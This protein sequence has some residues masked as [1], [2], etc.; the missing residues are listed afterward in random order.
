MLRTPIIKTFSDAERWCHEL[1]NELKMPFTV[2]AGDQTA[3]DDLRVSLS[4]GKLPAS[5]YPA[6]TQVKDNG[7]GSVG[8]FAYS[9]DDGEYI[10]LNT[11]IPHSWK[12]GTTI[13]PHIHFMTTT[14]VSPADNFK[15]GLEYNWASVGDTLG[16]TSNESI[17][18]STGVNS[19]YIHQ[20]ANI[21]ETGIS[22]AG[23][24]I[25]SVLICRLYRAAADTDNYG[26]SVI[27]TDFDIHFEKDT[28]GSRGI[29]SK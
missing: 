18:I 3:W 19:S 6:W 16:N 2:Y 29:V 8:T 13:Y 17:D 1:Y 23:H 21:S 27:I 10:F 4:T 25:S 14:D 11:Q 5:N 24:N 12:E 22:G 15:I 20:I 7:S 28:H 26:G 9:F